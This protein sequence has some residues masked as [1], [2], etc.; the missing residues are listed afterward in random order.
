MSI[1][2]GFTGQQFDPLVWKKIKTISFWKEQYPHLLF[3]IDVG[4]RWN[5]IQ[6]LIM[7]GLDLIVVGLILF[8]EQDYQKVIDNIN[9]TKK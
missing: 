4:A 1:K 2:P 3:Q 8:Q 9:K 7:S 6:Q 5:N